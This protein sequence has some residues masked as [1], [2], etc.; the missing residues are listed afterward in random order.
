MLGL[1]P[2]FMPK[3]QAVLPAG[4]TVHR[5]PVLAWKATSPGGGV[6]TVGGGLGGVSD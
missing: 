3:V 1:V 4:P 5:L 6:K 2:A